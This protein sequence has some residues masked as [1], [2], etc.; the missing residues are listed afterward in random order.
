MLVVTMQLLKCMRM[1]L[2]GTNSGDAC[3]TGFDLVLGERFETDANQ[4][5]GGRQAPPRPIACRVASVGRRWWKEGDGVRPIW[6]YSWTTRGEPTKMDGEREVASGEGSYDAR[7]GACYH[8]DPRA[9]RPVPLALSSFEGY[10]YM[11]Y[12]HGYYS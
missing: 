8:R 9:V 12:E 1:T 3:Y 11:T 4:P 6:K 2:N 7:R 5:H 10:G